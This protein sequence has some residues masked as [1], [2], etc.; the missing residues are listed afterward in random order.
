M[1]NRDQ[2]TITIS[3]CSCD[4]GGDISKDPMEA[5][6]YAPYGRTESQPLDL[7]DEWKLPSEP[8]A[9]FCFTQFYL[10]TLGKPDLEELWQDVSQ[11]NGV[12]K[13]IV[14][15]DDPVARQFITILIVLVYGA[16]MLIIQHGI[17]IA[18]R[19]W[20]RMYSGD[21]NNAVEPPSHLRLTPI[22]TQKTASLSMPLSDFCDGK[23]ELESEVRKTRSSEV[24]KEGMKT[25][26]LTPQQQCVAA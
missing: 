22:L 12:N 1:C 20:L 4:S 19:T 8:V 5:G 9:R 15:S 10:I 23:R 16:C 11:W 18:D 2:D 3:A 6:A 7:P 21:G 13:R 17:T 24:I 26:L 25:R 14:R